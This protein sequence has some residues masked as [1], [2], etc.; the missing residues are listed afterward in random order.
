MARRIA[1]ML[2]AALSVTALTSRESDGAEIRVLASAAVKNVVLELVP[3]FERQSGHKVSAQW[4]GTEGITKRVTGGEAV[5]LVIIAKPNIARLMQEGKIAEGSSVDIV[6]SGVGVAVRVGLPRPDVS[7]AEKTREAVLAAR[8]V[9]YSSGPSGFYIAELFKRMG[10]A[11]AIK[12]KAI[13]T[14]SGV[15]VAELLARGDADLGFQQVSELIHA[16]GIDYLGP[17]PAEIQNVTV[18]SAGLHAAAKE[19]DAAKALVR[20]LTAPEAAAT[21]R[22]AGMEPG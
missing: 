5:D 20:F 21:I 14:P 8:S 13:Q 15:Q 22:K 12:D 18:F 17:L 16:K 1:V 4:G 2:A 3:A 10:I 9:A 19:L 6:R 11:E 7:T